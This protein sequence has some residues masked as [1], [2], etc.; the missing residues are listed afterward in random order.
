MVAIATALAAAS[1]A[2]SYPGIGMGEGADC[3]QCHTLSFDEATEMVKSVNPEIEV[4]EIKPS[5]VAGLWEITILARGKRG[6][7]YIDFPK[8]H[9][10]TGSIIDVTSSMNLT[11]KRLYE[12]SKVEFSE[13][14]LEDALILGNPEAR[15]KAIVFDDPDCPYC[16]NLHRE[17]KSLVE[18]YEDI[19]FYI[20]LLPL[21][22]HPTAYKKAKAIV[23]LR[24]MALL[25]RSYDGRPLPEPTCETTEVDDTIELAERLGIATT[26]TIILPDGGVVQGFKDRETLLDLV[27]TA[28]RALEEMIA[29][30]QV[31][32]EAKRLR[33]LHEMEREDFEDLTGNDN[34][35]AFHE[36]LGK[37][38]SG[39]KRKEALERLSM[40]IDQKSDNLILYRDFIARYPDGLS[41]IPEEY[42]LLYVGPRELPLYAILQLLGE[43]MDEDQVAAKVSSMIGRYKEF[44]VEEVQRLTEMG[45]SDTIVDAMLEATFKAKRREEEARRQRHVT[46][47]ME[48]ADQVQAAIYDMQARLD[49]EM[50]E[51]PEILVDTITDE[52]GTPL[53]DKIERCTKLLNALSSCRRAV[54]VNSCRVAAQSE[55]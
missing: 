25:E 44:T 52:I 15:F 4:M 45:V 12:I 49:M 48:E 7:A 3:S 28:G 35:I 20:K 29:A 37:Y 46:R 18:E 54:N 39:K 10:I 6:I 21:K 30:R 23:C 1:P 41:A 31:E 14:P 51:D 27:E 50:T 2:Q 38:P 55:F 33:K 36:F 5:P 22:S 9:I 34:I 19:A 40:L 24:S 43:G 16:K 47:L 17:M 13:I 11:N 53:T 42:R 26:P 8:A 32:I